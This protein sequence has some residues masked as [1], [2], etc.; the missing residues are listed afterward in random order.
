[1]GFWTAAAARHALDDDVPGDVPGHAEIHPTL[2]TCEAAAR[3][4]AGGRH[5]R[6]PGAGVWVGSRVRGCARLI[7]VHSGSPYLWA[8]LRGVA[9]PAGPFLC[10]QVL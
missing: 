6:I 10:L 1:V 5:E 9:T 3:L 7:R 4:S 8:G 2:I